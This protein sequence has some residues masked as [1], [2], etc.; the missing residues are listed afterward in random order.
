M[1]QP[2]TVCLSTSSL[3]SGAVSS[4]FVYLKELDSKGFVVYSN[5]DTSRKASDINSNGWASL[6]FWWHEVE[7][8]IRV[9][10]TTERL[11]RKESQ[12]YFSVRA[13]GSKV[14][15][16]ASEQSKVLPEEEGGRDVLE[17]RVKDVKKM[18]EDVKDEDIP[19]PE[20][21]GGMRIVP[22][23]VEFW[24]GRE[25]RL[26]DRFRYTRVE[27]GEEGDL[28]DGWKIERLSP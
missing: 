23:M 26:H 20:F 16:W 27:K 10:G 25:S 5:W 24:Q 12:V 2:E 11:S 28:G 22:T 13:R 8:Q 6:A 21:W 15:A 18:F 17:R 19:V 14:G 3:P 4:R 9:E 7:R 1:Y